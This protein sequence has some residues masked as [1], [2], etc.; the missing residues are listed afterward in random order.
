V[1]LG[2]EVQKLRAA[3]D[4]NFART[5]PTDAAAR[6][7]REVAAL[8]AFAN[9]LAY[10]DSLE[11][12]F[13]AALDAIVG[14]LDCDRA[15]ILIFDQDGVMRF[16]AWRGL[17]GVYRKAVEG[18][19][20]WRVDAANPQPIVVQD[21]LESGESDALKETIATEGIRALAFIPLIADG[22]LIG[23]FMTY[24][25]NP[26]EFEATEISLACTIATQIALGIERKRAQEAQRVLVNELQHRT[27]NLL[28]VVQAM[29]RQT[30]RGSG[31][32]EEL[33]AVFESRLQ[34]LARANHQLTTS[35]WAGAK[36]IELIRLALEPFLSRVTMSGN[37]IVLDPHQTQNFAMAL[38]ELATNAVKYGSLSRAGGSVDLSWAIDDAQQDLRFRWLERDG[39]PVTEPQKKGFGSSLIASMFKNAAFTYRTDG[40]VCELSVPMAR[41]RHTYDA[42]ARERTLFD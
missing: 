39:P 7:M 19:S 14:G 29:A 38:H 1:E 12:V 13:E 8:Y 10:S 11:A 3:A 32:P 16:A 22:R 37:D 36:L 34:A 28:A 6:L 40:I 21:I 35:N 18:H 2:R 26:H 23:K 4:E 33:R 25:S 15:S 31:P 27:N 30:L 41:A 42:L 9:R 5:P 24:Y 20:P 17:S